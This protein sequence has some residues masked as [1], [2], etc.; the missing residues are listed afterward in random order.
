MREETSCLKR[1]VSEEM[2]LLKAFFLDMPERICLVPA[3]GE[4]IKGYLTANGKG[5]PIVSKLLLQDLDKGRSQSMDLKGHQLS[6][7]SRGRKDDE[8]YHRPQIRD[9]LEY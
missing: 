5:Q 2:D 1:L 4:N 6:S 7:V 8:L 3:I 9:V